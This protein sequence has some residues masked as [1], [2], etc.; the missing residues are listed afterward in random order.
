MGT[1]ELHLKDKLSSTVISDI[2]DTMMD[3]EIFLVSGIP[4]MF[5][6]A[7]H[8][9]SELWV[10]LFPLKPFKE[11]HVHLVNYCHQLKSLQPGAKR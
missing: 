4:L 6:V 1:N 7:T 9:S 8:V 3:D 2:N 10:S 11:L 5:V